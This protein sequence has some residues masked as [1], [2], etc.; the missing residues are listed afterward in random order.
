MSENSSF[1]AEPGLGWA[2][3]GSLYSVLI[4]WPNMPLLLIVAANTLEAVEIAVAHWQQEY[5]PDPE[6][7]P[8]VVEVRRVHTGLLGRDE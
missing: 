5:S 1:D 8:E 2:A 4:E 3:I 6:Q 7:V